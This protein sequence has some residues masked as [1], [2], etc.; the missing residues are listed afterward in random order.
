MLLWCNTHNVRFGRELCFLQR[1][2][3][4]P[5]DRQG[6]TLVL[7]SVVVVTADVS[8]QAKVCDLHRQVLVDPEICTYHLVA[9]TVCVV[10]VVNLG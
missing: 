6:A 9:A 2:E 4:H 3:R 5:S 7:H 1:F 8:R 10:R